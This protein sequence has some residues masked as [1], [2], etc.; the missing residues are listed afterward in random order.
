MTLPQL[1]ISIG[2]NPRATHVGRRSTGVVVKIDHELYRLT[3]EDA[4]AD[5]W[6]VLDEVQV[7]RLGAI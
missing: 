5:D 6:E 2:S 7:E 1:L 4:A 3:H